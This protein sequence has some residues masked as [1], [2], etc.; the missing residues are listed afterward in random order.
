[1]LQM[2]N[3]KDCNASKLEYNN[4]QAN[5]YSVKQTV[6]TFPIELV[7]TNA[8]DQVRER[9]RDLVGANVA[10]SESGDGKAELRGPPPELPFI[11][12]NIANVIA[13][14]DSGALMRIMRF[15]QLV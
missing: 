12:R 5:V 7:N 14:G 9:K 2:N 15:M 11:G 10:A 8:S 13:K 1:M 4:L 6:G 3:K